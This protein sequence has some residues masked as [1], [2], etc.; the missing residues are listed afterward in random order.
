MFDHVKYAQAVYSI[1]RAAQFVRQNMAGKETLPF[2][3]GGDFNALPISSAVSAFYNE[4]IL[5]Q[6]D[7]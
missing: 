4:D 7:D 2:I 1:E 6:A 5:A 3:M